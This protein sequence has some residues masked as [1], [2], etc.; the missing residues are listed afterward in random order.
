VTTD[1][2]PDEVLR[3]FDGKLRMGYVATA[4]PDAHLVVVPA[5]VM[6]HEGRVKISSP[7]DTFKIRNLRQDPHIVVCV[8]D[9][10]DPRRYLMI[11]GIADLADDAGRQFLDWLART[12]M[13]LDSYPEEPPGIPR[14]VITILPERFIFAGT[15]ES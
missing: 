14:S 2:I 5:G 15:H 4:R 13:G 6:L 8:P 3:H 9:P 7:T 11:R 1:P 12:H 10:D